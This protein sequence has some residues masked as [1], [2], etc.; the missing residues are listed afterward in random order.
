MPYCKVAYD[1]CL[2]TY[3]FH[4]PQTYLVE[5]YVGFEYY[6]TVSWASLPLIKNSNNTSKKADNKKLILIMNLFS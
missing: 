2:F 3:H 6:N 1:H 5:N 4:V